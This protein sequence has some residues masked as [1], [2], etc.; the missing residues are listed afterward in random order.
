MSQSETNPLEEVEQLLKQGQRD[1]ALLL[2]R[3]GLDQAI[4]GGVPALIAAAWMNL[5]QV[6]GALGDFPETAKSLEKALAALPG[7]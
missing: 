4:Q 3:Q 6:H 1:K 5:A 7:Q 2:V